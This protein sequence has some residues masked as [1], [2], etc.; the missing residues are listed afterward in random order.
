M[1]VL[2]A[3][4]VLSLAAM[5]ASAASAETAK[6]LTLEEPITAL[7]GTFSGGEA[8]LEGEKTKKTIKSTAVT[9]T[10]KECKELE[11]SKTDTNLCVGLLTFT[12]TKQEELSC[13][14]ENLAKT[15]D[16]EGVILVKIDAHLADEETTGGVLQPILIAKV[17]GVDGD[18]ELIINCGGTKERVLGRVPCLVE[19]GLKEVLKGGT[20]TLTCVEKEGK[21]VT[22]KCKETAQLCKELAEDP[23]R[24]ILGTEVEP[25]GQS[26]ALSGSFNKDILIDD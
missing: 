7:E 20:F 18:N 8:K 19:P 4:A 9:A 16:A 10:L 21:Q 12:G 24:A 23:L 25:A 11:A 5:A 2:A 22:G 15:K 17:L 13:R 14:S 3:I 6:L 1:L 26:I